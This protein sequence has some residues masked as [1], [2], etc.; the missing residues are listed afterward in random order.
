V[1]VAVNGYDIAYALGVA[2]A[3]PVWLSKPASRHKVLSA[4]GQRMGHVLPREDS[5]PAILIHAVS[6]GE[7]N[8]TRELVA[9][10]HAARP[11]LHI[12]ISTTTVTGYDRGRQLYGNKPQLTV[13][14]FP[15]DFSSA[16]NT[17]LDA[18]DPSL[19]VLMEG[20]IWPNFLLQCDR[21]K[22][23]V[24]LVNGR[25]TESAFK[26]YRKIR[27]ITAQMLRRIHTLCAQDQVYADRFKALG[28]PVDSVQITGTM[29]F[30]TAHI[31]DSVAGD[32]QLALDLGLSNADPLC[33]CGSTGP[34]EESLL[35]DAYR[36]L[37]NQFPTLRLA[38]I[39]RKPERFDEVADLIT[40]KG[41]PLLRRSNHTPANPTDRPI[42]LG[43]TMGELRKFYS[44]ATIV[45]VGRSLIDLGSRQWG[46]DMIEPAALGK[47][48]IIGPWTHNFA[49][50]VRSFRAANAMVEVSATPQMIQT[51]TTW[52]SD[53]SAAT[54]IGRRAQRVVK[55]NQGATAR[56][57]EVI[58][59]VAQSDPRQIR[60]PS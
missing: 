38:I 47:P 13:V 9:Q 55:E 16:I 51:I 50:A 39:P 27:F 10:F 49:E 24:V 17:L 8:A 5:G 28:S 15:L 41:F 32:H 20:E 4:L 34:G 31:A 33:V 52:L 56:H 37:L 29:K 45:F 59:A 25:M 2:A 22:I 44:L 11:D 57:V 6:R 53:P 58:L 18:L 21:R 36:T 23:P 14:R 1:S 48:V 26:R 12:I 30:D 60:E 43:D 42:I 3:S 54:E 46:S 19:I 7:V 40:A 35:L